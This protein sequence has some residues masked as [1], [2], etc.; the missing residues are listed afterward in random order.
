[1]N[2]DHYAITIE[3]DLAFQLQLMS[4]AIDE[5]FGPSYA[6]ANPRLV[7]TLMQNV[8]IYA[9]AEAIKGKQKH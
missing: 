4:E 6:N 2:F 9:L 8:A 7:S 1:L 3:N 5:V